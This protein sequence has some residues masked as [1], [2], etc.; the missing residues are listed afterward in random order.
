MPSNWRAFAATLHTAF[1]HSGAAYL[2]HPQ[3][4]LY[5]IRIPKAGNTSIGRAFL[6]AR[7]QYLPDL[8]AT[9][10]NLLCQA[11][12]Q[13]RF[14]ASLKHFTGFTLVRHPL[15]RLVSVYRDFFEFPRDDFFIYQGYLFNILPQRLSFADFVQRVVS[16]PVRLLDGHLMPQHLLIKPFQRPGFNVKIFKLEEPEKWKDFLQAHQLNAF[17]DNA[18]AFDYNYRQYYTPSVKKKALQ[19]YGSDCRL[20]GYEQ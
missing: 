18:S 13:N 2:V 20:F 5:Y 3:K 12:Q 16:I 11:W 14:T 19:L 17:H 1:W 10:V 9:Q 7:F 8:S 15:H 6:E 4:P